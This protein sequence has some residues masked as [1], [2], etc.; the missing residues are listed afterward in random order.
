MYYPYLRGKQ[1]ELLAVREL[2]E[3]NLI[4]DKVI[5][6]IEPIRETATLKKTLCK[7][8][9]NG[10]EI[11]TIINPQVG[12]YDLYTENHPI[13]N[14]LIVV[15][16]DAI[17]MSDSQ[18]VLNSLESLK[19][20]QKFVSF[21]FTRDDIKNFDLLE[22]NSLD[23]A[24][25]FVKDG[26]RY[27]RFFKQ[28]GQKIGLIRD[29][30]EKQS[31]NADYASTT[32]EFFS[33]DHLFFDIEGYSAFSDFSII[34]ESYIDGGFAPV[35][36]AIHIVYFDSDQTL[37]IKHFVSDS[38]DDISDPAGK[39]QEALYKL[40]NWAEEIEEINESYAIGEFRKLLREK[41]YPGLGF[42]KK[43]SIMHHLE[44]MNK[45]LSRR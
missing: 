9:E 28:K 2:L 42:V 44:I 23:A 41:R 40:V 31:R 30:F 16:Y 7:Y 26:N 12:D 21:Y 29:A 5:P 17:L 25:N 32:D 13:I 27:S 3:R 22:S 33:D 11:Y 4:T 35:A 34:G 10:K 39:F 37:R 38:N 43:L 19:Q 18:S 36:V 45:Y 8:F 20:S 1:Y 14:E 24:I 6:I 15:Y